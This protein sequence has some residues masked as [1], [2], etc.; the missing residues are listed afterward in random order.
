V[1]VAQLCPTLC[2]TIDSILPGSSVHEFHGF[3]SLVGYS[4]WGRK[5]SDM[6]ERLH[7]LSGGSDSKESAWNAGDQGSIPR[8]GRSTGEGNENLLQYSFPEKFMDRGAWQ[9][10]VY[11]VTKSRTQLSNQ[12]SHVQLSYSFSYLTCIP[13]CFCWIKS[14]SI[15]V[16]FEMT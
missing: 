11:G 1:L 15:S 12:H 10:R 5:E 7:F 4:P 9:D 16:G 8:V 14:G 2:D 3:R 13:T 6:T